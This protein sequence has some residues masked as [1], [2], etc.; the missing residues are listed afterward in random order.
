MKEKCPTIPQCSTVKYDL[1]VEAVLDAQ[2]FGNVRFSFATKFIKTTESEVNYD[3]QSLVGEVGGTLGMFLGFSGLGI[4][5]MVIRFQ[6]DWQK[7]INKRANEATSILM[8]LAFCY[9][10]TQSVQ[11]YFNEF[12]STTSM[13]IQ[14]NMQLMLPKL[15]FCSENRSYTQH[16]LSISS[17]DTENINFF[18]SLEIALKSNPN[19]D[20][21]A[22]GYNL[23][24]PNPFADNVYIIDQKQQQIVKGD[25]WSVTYHKMYGLCHTFNISNA[26]NS[27]M[28]DSEFITL[29]FDSYSD[30]IPTWQPYNNEGVILMHNDNDL[31][32]ANEH[33]SVL[34]FGKNQSYTIEKDTFTFSPPKY[35]SCGALY[36]QSCRD[37][38]LNNFI[39][40]EYDCNIPFFFTGNHVKMNLSLPFCSN[41]IVLAAFGLKDRHTDK[42]PDVMPC[43]FSRYHIISETNNSIDEVRI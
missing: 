43:E 41:E 1:K 19:I 23:F 10:S 18:M 29:A 42:C 39:Q 28:S 32:N 40:M 35:T 37:F 21:Q 25:V 12:V 8:W 4:L 33:S 38:E 14:G 6:F 5:Q 2:D 17:N 24:W 36:P 11:R 22:I 13:P 16:A 7:K 3:I 30:R 9:W 27:D 31:P 15:T 26:K 20:L 34:S